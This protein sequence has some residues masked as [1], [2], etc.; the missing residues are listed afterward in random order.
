MRKTFVAEKSVVRAFR[1]LEI[2]AESDTPLGVSELS[3]QL[4]WTKS[5]TF[6]LLTALTQL[7]Y[8]RQ[9]QPSMNYQLSHKV[10]Q[11]ASKSVRRLD[12]RQI[13]QPYLKRLLELTGETARLSILAGDHAVCIEQ[14]E[15]NHP[16]TVQTQVGG[17]LPLGC[18][19]TGKAILAFQDDQTIKKI[20]RALEAFTKHT[21][22]P[23]EKLSKDLEL[24]KRRGFSINKGERHLSVSGV[25]APIYD[26]N[27]KVEAAIG[28]SGPTDRFP[29][30][31]MLQH[32]EVIK[33]L[34]DDLSEEMGWSHERA[35]M[36]ASQPA[37]S[38][39]KRVKAKEVALQK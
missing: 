37:E 13:A 25:A 21:L 38:R 5:G 24:T 3:R 23:A 31:L 30:E 33:A 20:S 39:T 34:A 16:V 17:S 6:R 2:L 10:V 7:G 19:A 11:L 4:A 27:G 22:V 26:R 15:S 8:L 14:M 12:L 36:V 1:L 29:L 9:L 28:I 32:G 18:S 35:E